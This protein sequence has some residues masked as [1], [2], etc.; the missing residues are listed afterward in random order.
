MSKIPGV[1]LQAGCAAYGAAFLNGPGSLGDGIEAAYFAI[2]DHDDWV[3]AEPESWC[4]EGLPPVG[5]GVCEYLGAHQYDE[6][7]VVNIFAHYGHTVF[8]DYG[9]GWRD[10]TDPLRFR[11]VRTAEQIAADERLHEVRNAL[12]AIHAGQ[13]QFPNDLVRGNIVAATVEAMIDAGY[14]KQVNP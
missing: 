10:E 4:G 2:H 7:A 13:Q 1:I 14:R 9:D 6:W 3:R 5:K 8:V 12:S 11:P